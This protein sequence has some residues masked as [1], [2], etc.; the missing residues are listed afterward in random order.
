MLP[1]LGKWRWRFAGSCC[2]RV[3]AADASVYRALP[4]LE[5]PSV[6]L[7]LRSLEVLGRGCIPRLR[8]L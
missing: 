7:L 4:W 3:E 5:P 2:C 6:Q 1:A 8:A